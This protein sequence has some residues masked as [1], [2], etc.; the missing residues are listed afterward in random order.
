[1]MDWSQYKD[2]DKRQALIHSVKL[3]LIV[4]VF[5][6]SFLSNKEKAIQRWRIL[7]TKS[8]NL[9]VPSFLMYRKTK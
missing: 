3:I 7:W 8:P 5:I 6:E 9:R 4:P 1:M 2:Y